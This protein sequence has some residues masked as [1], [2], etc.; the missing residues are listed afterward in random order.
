M[1]SAE[2]LEAFHNIVVEIQ[3]RCLFVSDLNGIELAFILYESGYELVKIPP[4][5]RKVPID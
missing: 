2:Q 3:T 5:Y 4:I 1:T